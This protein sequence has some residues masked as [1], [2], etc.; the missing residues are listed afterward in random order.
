MW[1]IR[2]LQLSFT[3]GVAQR[4][5]FNPIAADPDV[6]FVYMDFEV[7]NGDHTGEPFVPQNNIKIIIG[8]YAFDAQDLDQL[9]ALRI[10][11]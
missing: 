3:T 4:G 7:R 11:S 8:E 10:C 5:G 9:S 1:E 6:I 2:I